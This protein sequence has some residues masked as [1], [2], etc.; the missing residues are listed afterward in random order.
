MEANNVDCVDQKLDTI[1]FT[2]DFIPDTM[3][4][5]SGIS[6]SQ[7]VPGGLS[8]DTILSIRAPEH[9]LELREPQY[10]SQ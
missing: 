5:C 10:T 1:S 7:F 2:R 6:L 9:S 8:T 3:F 4:V